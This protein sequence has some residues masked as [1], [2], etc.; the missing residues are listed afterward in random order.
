[1]TENPLRQT[2]SRGRDWGWEVIN[3]IHG[4]KFTILMTVVKECFI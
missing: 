3:V 1:M 4:V 2:R